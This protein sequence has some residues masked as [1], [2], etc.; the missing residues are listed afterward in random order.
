MP[1]AH[2]PVLRLAGRLTLAALAAL[3]AALHAEPVRAE[4]PPP[5]A[6]PTFSVPAQAADPPELP[7]AEVR[8]RLDFIEERLR[9]STPAVQRWWYGWMGGWTALMF[10]QAVAAVAT[11]DVKLRKDAAVGGA[12]STLPVFALGVFPFP[13]T[14]AAH[15]LA[16]MPS[17]TPAERRRKL[18][19]AEHLLEASAAGE[20]RNRAWPNHLL[21]G[22]VSVGVGLLLALHYQRPV[23]GA[24]AAGAGIG[25]S[26][27]QIFT[28]PMDAVRDWDAYRRSIGQTVRPPPQQGVLWS[29]T[30]V[31]GGAGIVG[32]F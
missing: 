19:S 7:D 10:V 16:S 8:R 12:F 20:A 25:L 17:A 2:T 32:R 11:T 21:V 9:R 14:T 24:L 6:T 23:T 15:R 28:Q 27:A 13:A 18:A 5:A 29:V 22:G 31:A 4:P 26:E 3:G 1:L 30:P